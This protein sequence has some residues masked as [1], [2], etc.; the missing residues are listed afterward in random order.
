MKNGLFFF[1]EG[2]GVIGKGI[3]EG[4]GEMDWECDWGVGK[5]AMLLRIV[6]GRGYQIAQRQ[7]A[8]S[9]TIRAEDCMVFIP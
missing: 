7:L 2:G 9:G 6:E 8:R 3:G 4:D 5:A 1:L